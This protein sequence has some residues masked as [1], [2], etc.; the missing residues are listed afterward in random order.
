MKT[1]M[2]PDI[3]LVELGKQFDQLIKDETR[4]IKSARTQEGKKVLA[5]L[6]P[7]LARKILSTK[8]AT[9][10]GLAIKAR[11]FLWTCGGPENTAKGQISV[12]IQAVFDIVGDIIEID[13]AEKLNPKTKG[14]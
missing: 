12:D 11:A 13:K 9:L 14:K 7:A 2:H 8:A 6:A 3:E 1:T 5:S 10:E 4:L